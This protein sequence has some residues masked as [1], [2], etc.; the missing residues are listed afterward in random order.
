MY[1]ESIWKVVLVLDKPGQGISDVTEDTL[2]FAL[3]LP[4]T[5]DYTESE[6]VNWKDNFELASP[7]QNGKIVR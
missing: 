6:N 5:L 1:P 2:A 7:Y 4:N 3:Y